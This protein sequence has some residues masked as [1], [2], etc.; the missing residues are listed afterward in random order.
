MGGIPERPLSAPPPPR[1]N[2]DLLAPPSISPTLAS[3]PIRQKSTFTNGTPSKAKGMQLG[4]S[5]TP[6]SAIIATEF[7]DINQADID[8][9]WGHDDLIDVNADAD[10]WSTCPSPGR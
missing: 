3:P 10:D 5:K 7:D 6:I 1:T 2:G 8:D 9:A 4:A